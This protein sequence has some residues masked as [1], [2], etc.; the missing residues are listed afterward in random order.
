MN[1]AS[2]SSTGK[3]ESRSLS[4]KVSAYFQYEDDRAGN[5]VLKIDMNTL[6]GGFKNQDENGKKFEAL[7]NIYKVRARDPVVS[8]LIF[9]DVQR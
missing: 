3:E 9:S 6:I 1:L 7:R 4:Q 5:E 8:D 2:G